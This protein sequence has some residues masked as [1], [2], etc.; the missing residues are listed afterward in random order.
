MD[1]QVLF[2][3]SQQADPAPQT[4]F[5]YGCKITLSYSG[6]NNP[7]AVHAIRDVLIGSISTQKG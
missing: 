1:N 4:F 3:S 5:L 6:E 7:A 2:P